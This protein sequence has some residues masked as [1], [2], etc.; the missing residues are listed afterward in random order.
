MRPGR[1]EDVAG[2]VE[3]SRHEVAIGRQDATPDEERMRRMLARFDWETRS[4][5][6]ERG[7]RLEGSVLVTVRPSPDGLLAFVYSASRDDSFAGLVRWGVQF[8]QAAGAAIVQAR[9]TKGF[10]APLGEAG[11][12]LARPWWRMDRGLSDGLPAVEPVAGYELADG[13]TVEP[14]S[15]GDTFNRSFADHWRF[16][17][18]SEEEVLDGKASDLSL[19]AVTSKGRHP[20][21][22]TLS[23]VQTEAADAR[24]VPF[25]LVRSVG[26]VPEHRR[27]GLAGWLVS[28]S[29]HRLRRAGARTASLYVDGLNP[30]R[31]YDVYRKVGFE[32]AH[33]AEVWEA[34]FP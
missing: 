1:P 29:L 22:I 15:W 28:E 19:M 11:L 32:V 13:A 12:R 14:G 30:Q 33:E 5:V 26:T 24:P 8:A 6:I 3:L 31:A 7:G 9:V 34:T 27:R 21:A 18:H 16:M 4:R 10:G 23:H 20:A 25:G 17:P 2:I